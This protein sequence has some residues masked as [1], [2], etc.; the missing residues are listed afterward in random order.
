MVWQSRDYFINNPGNPSLLENLAQS[1]KSAS[2]TSSFLQILLLVIIVGWIVCGTIWLKALKQQ[3][4]S[5]K[6]ALKDLFLT[7]RR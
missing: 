4:V 5:Y 1:I 2:Q 3:K 6:V 7:I